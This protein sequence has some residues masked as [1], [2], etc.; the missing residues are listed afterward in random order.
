MNRY[1]LPTNKQFTAYILKVYG[2]TEEEIA[3]HENVS[4]RAIRARLF[5]LK[6]KM[7]KLFSIWKSNN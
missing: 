4:R 5:L 1:K 7:P 6:K 2:L 3:K